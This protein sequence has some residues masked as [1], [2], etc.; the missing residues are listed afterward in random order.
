MNSIHVFSRIS[1]LGKSLKC[2]WD[3]FMKS[4]K[5]IFSLL[6]T[7]YVFAVAIMTI[8]SY[9]H[10]KK[11]L[12]D[13]LDLTLYSAAMALDSVVGKDFHDKY[14]INVPMPHNEFKPVTKKIDGLSSDFN[15]HHIFTITK[16]KGYFYYVA[17]NETEEDIQKKKRRFYYT[18]YFAPP[19][20]LSEAYNSKE[21]VYVSL[22]ETGKKM[23]YVFIPK[24]TPHGIKYI[25]GANVSLEQVSSKMKTTL[26]Y[27]VI[28]DMFFLIPIIPAFLF[29]RRMSRKREKELLKKIYTDPITGLPNRNKFIFDSH[30]LCNQ[31]ISA[32]IFDIDSFREI[33]DLFGGEVGDELLKDI[34]EILDENIDRN[35]LLYKFPADEYLVVLRNATIEKTTAFAQRIINEISISTFKNSGHEISLTI[36]AGI[37]EETT[38]YKKLLSTANIAKNTAKQDKEAIIVYNKRL[39]KEEKFEDNLFWLKEL[40]D[41]LAEDRIIPFFQPIKNNLNGEISKYEALVRLIKKDGE[42]VSPYKFLGVAKKSKLYPELTRTVILKAFKTFYDQKDKSVSIN[43]A[44][45]DML[46]KDTMEYLFKMVEIYE[47][48]GRVIAEIVESESIKD[49]TQIYKLVDTFKEKGIQVAIDDFGSGYSNLEYLFRLKTDYIKLDGTLI[50]NILTH[51]SSRLIVY[52]IA[53]FAAKMRIDIVAEFVSDENIQKEIESF[54]IKYS[55]GFHIGKPSQ[56]PPR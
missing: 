22:N 10:S 25:L 17:S 47:M 50:K 9:K 35:D 29:I 3:L 45:S 38:D 41:A 26:I 2:I 16:F 27:S 36:T 33:N 54:G 13:K 7:F 12:Y 24:T 11:S 28:V 51:K 18:I 39:G 37:T 21:P 30:S 31:W 49:Y 56:F 23:R 1:Y 46:N 42:V 43:L 55:Q 8:G 19:K 34:A 4:E 32:I 53:F 14:S 48:Q 40:K 44:A 20:A 6:L 15:V 5:I 52:S